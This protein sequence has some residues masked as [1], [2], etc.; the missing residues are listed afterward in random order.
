VIGDRLDVIGSGPCTADPTTYAD[1]LGV[2]RA[3]GLAEAVPAAVRGHLEAGMR[4]E[5]PESPKAGEAC[6]SAVRATVVA[7]NR[8]ALR[9]AREAAEA[10]GLRFVTLAGALQGEAR[11]AGRRLAAL[12]R[13]ARPRAPTLVAAGGET[14]VALRGTGRGGRNQE[15]ALA[16]AVGLAG[17]PGATLLAAGTDGTD[18]PTDAAGA[19]ADGGTVARGAACGA[20][21]AEALAGNDSHSFFLREGGLLRTGPTGT[22]VMDLAF[23]LLLPT[24]A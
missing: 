13:A 11:E 6:F 23:L 8:D 18:G 2:L 24:P 4:G 1:A 21:A 3:R 5:R 17:L 9:A 12:A 19:I 20:S 7:S 16:A 22:N 15:L 10:A 14:T